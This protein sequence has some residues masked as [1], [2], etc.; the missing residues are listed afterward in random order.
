MICKLCKHQNNNKNYKIKLYFLIL[1]LTN[2]LWKSF[3][4]EV[5]IDFLQIKVNMNYVLIKKET[6]ILH[7]TAYLLILSFFISIFSSIALAQTNEQHNIIKNTH[8]NVLKIDKNK[9]IIQNNFLK[10]QYTGEEIKVDFFETNIKN[11]FKIL[12]KVSGKNFVVDNDVNASVTL[13]LDEP[14]PWDQVLDLILKTNHLGKIIENSIIRITTID[15]LKKEEEIKQAV[16][17][18]K[19]SAIEHQKSLEPLITE[20]ISI[21]YSNAKIDIR[22]HIEKILTPDKGHLSVDSRT[23]MIIITDVQDKINKAKELIYRLD[24]VTPQ[25][26]IT[27]RIVD[28]AKNFSRQLGVEWNLGSNHESN[29]FGGN[30]NYDI[31]MNYPIISNS[32]LGFNFSRII[33]TS[34]TLD[35]KLTASEIKGEVKIISS[36]QI[37]TLNNKKA[38]IKQGLEIG[39]ISGVDDNGNPV[40]SFKSIDLSLEVT[41]HVTPDNRVAMIIKIKKND[42][43]GYSESGVPSLSKNE[44]ETELLVNDKE[45]IIIGGIVKNTNNQTKIGFPILSSIPVIGR[46]FR[47]NTN[48]EQRNELL[49]FITPSIVQLKQRKKK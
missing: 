12:S 28:V 17:T 27:A 48:Q 33:G 10:T 34:L 20:Y 13:T 39:Y 15:T 38:I 43:A 26:M 49:I 4:D 37:L 14:V 45:T 46:I 21:N 5:K 42:L 36:P 2:E 19:K 47:S 23:N 1:K 22:P 18:A 31:A 29:T 41:P 16:F 8:V 9:K 7:K 40:T 6:S 24:K 30:V 44:A 35:A 32:T 3:Y 25:I 11:V